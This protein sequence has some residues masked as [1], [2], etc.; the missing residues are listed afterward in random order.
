[1]RNA[2]INGTRAVASPTKTLL[3]L[4]SNANVRPSIY[5]II[6]GS[7]ATP[8]DNALEFVLQRYT[9]AG[10]G[11]SVTPTPADEDDPATQC[12]ALVNLSAEPTYTS[13]AVLLDIPLNQR[14]TQRWIA[15][16]G[17]ELKMAATAAHGCGLQPIHASFTGNVTATIH[18]ED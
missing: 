5:D 12:T 7:T 6:V 2:S 4:T 18:F 13:G 15:A 1:M 3:A 16:P 14:A 11:T 8:A 10:T 9:A 17:R